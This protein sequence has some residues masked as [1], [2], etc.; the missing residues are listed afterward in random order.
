MDT[1]APR[2]GGRC[3]DALQE[4]RVCV[5]RVSGDGLAFRVFWE[6]TASE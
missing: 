5:S 3:Q 4:R 6:L 2:P 1:D